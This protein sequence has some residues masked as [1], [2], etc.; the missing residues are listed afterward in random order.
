MRLLI[1]RAD[2]IQLLPPFHRT[3]YP[4][5]ARR[6]V[7]TQYSGWKRT[8]VW[9]TGL[10]ATLTTFLIVMLLVSLFALE[11]DSDEKTIT[12]KWRPG[13]GDAEIVNLERIFLDDKELKKL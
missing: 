12:N 8:A 6:H 3:T 4:V 9:L 10:V 11:K 5:L 2:S 7:M 1:G 13:S